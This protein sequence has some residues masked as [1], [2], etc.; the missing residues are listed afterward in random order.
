M[1]PGHVSKD[2]IFLRT[3][4]KYPLG[5]DLPVKLS[6]KHEFILFKVKKYLIYLYNTF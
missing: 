1:T 3:C 2:S 5:R 4:G 6:A